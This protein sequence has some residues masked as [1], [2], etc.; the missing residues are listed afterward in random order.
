MSAAS[1]LRGGADDRYPGQQVGVH[2]VSTEKM[3]KDERLKR[4]ARLLRQTPKQIAKSFGR[5]GAMSEGAL[6]AAERQA[7]VEYR[8]TPMAYDA[9]FGGTGVSL[10]RTGEEVPLNADELLYAMKAFRRK[11]KQQ[12]DAKKRE[13]D[14]K[15]TGE[16][17]DS[18]RMPQLVHSCD[19]AGP[20]LTYCDPTV[21]GQCPESKDLVGTPYEN[22][23]STIGVPPNN[24]V[25]KCVPKDLIPIVTETAQKEESMDR[26]LH[27][28]MRVISTNAEAIME[29]AGWRN[30]A[31][32]DAI[33]EMA[34]SENGNMCGAL[35]GKKDRLSQRCM[36][37]KVAAKLLP[38][39]SPRKA[40]AI[41]STDGRGSRT[42]YDN[43]E[44]LLRSLKSLVNRVALWR[45]KLRSAVESVMRVPNFVRLFNRLGLKMADKYTDHMKQPLQWSTVTSYMARDDISTAEAFLKDASTCEDTQREMERIEA[46]LKGGGGDA[47]EGEDDCNM[48]FLT[49]LKIVHR[50]LRDENQLRNEFASWVSADSKQI[51][52]LQKDATCNEHRNNPDYCNVMAQQCG[53]DTGMTVEEA[54]AQCIK[55]PG[56]ISVHESNQDVTW[57]VDSY[58]DYGNAINFRRIVNPEV[59]DMYAEYQKQ[60]WQQCATDSRL[61]RVRVDELAKSH[62]KQAKEMLVF[63]GRHYPQT[64]RHLDGTRYNE[65]V[66]RAEERASV[67]TLSVEDQVEQAVR[68]ALSSLGVVGSRP[69]VS[70][71]D[72][73]SRKAEELF[74]RVQLQS[75][76]EE[77]LVFLDLSLRSKTHFGKDTD[78]EKTA[79]A[80][81]LIEKFNDSETTVARKQAMI[82]ALNARAPVVEDNEG[83]DDM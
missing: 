77:P 55:M 27:K 68:R 64:L 10:Q 67:Q 38:D 23:W 65:A 26:R 70:A 34:F 22:I 12:A 79:A 45:R 29:L 28:V 58:D 72:A 74:S 73:S 21:E 11:L 17:D 62:N 7:G 9:H 56:G 40:E 35:N 20:G 81:A 6:Q 24:K 39:K 52:A 80:T 50:M 49:L 51:A 8:T 41:A 66:Q 63:L 44:E 30:T 32:C 75:A 83:Y 25:V 60:A 59:M 48:R 46:L 4:V 69:D 31:P 18:T 14:R 3:T 71:A 36:D 19:T 16:Y 53:I 43:P 42:C 61:S 2:E 13:E 82:Q 5:N 37:H 1:V 76:D 47:C 33:P 57:T 15:L 54:D 78:A